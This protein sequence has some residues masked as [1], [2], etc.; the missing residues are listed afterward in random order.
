MTVSI[1]AL[2][3]ERVPKPPIDGVGIQLRMS[4]GN[5]IYFTPEVAAQWLP[6]LE[7]IANEG[8]K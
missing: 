4:S 1:T 6:V 7:A 3:V 2:D 8:N 5:Y